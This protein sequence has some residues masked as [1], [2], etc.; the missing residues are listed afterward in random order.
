MPAEAHRPQVVTWKTTRHESPHLHPQLP[1]PNRVSTPMH[2][3]YAASSSSTCHVPVLCP[4]HRNTASTR[5]DNWAD[6]LVTSTLTGTMPHDCTLRHS[7]TVPQHHTL[8]TVPLHPRLCNN[9][10]RAC[11]PQDAA[12]AVPRQQTI[13]G[14]CNTDRICRCYRRVEHVANAPGTKSRTGDHA[15]GDKDSKQ[16]SLCQASCIPQPAQFSHSCTGHGQLHTSFLSTQLLTVSFPGIMASSMAMPANLMYQSQ[17]LGGGARHEDLFK[18]ELP[19]E[20]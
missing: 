13:R 20:A 6:G 19:A 15:S 17:R 8:P 14:G 16:A 11:Q 7:T 2:G 12:C 18:S 9:R 5:S 10:P 4:P 1:P 3:R